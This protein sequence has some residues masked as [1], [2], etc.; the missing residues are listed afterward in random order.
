VK[1]FIFGEMISK[2]II[3][4]E[5]AYH[6]GHFRH[7]KKACPGMSYLLSSTTI[8]CRDRPSTPTAYWDGVLDE[9][10]IYDTALSAQQIQNHYN[11]AL[12]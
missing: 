10:V 12:Q 3:H 4:Y 2:N 1:V 11:E 8:E 6:A 9:V 7:G 5:C